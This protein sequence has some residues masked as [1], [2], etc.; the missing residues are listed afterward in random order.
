MEY[1][2]LKKANGWA[3][4]IGAITEAG[5][6]Y[7]FECVGNLEVLREAFLSTHTVTPSPYHSASGF[8]ISSI[9]CPPLIINVWHAYAGMGTDCTTWDSPKP[10]VAA[11]PSNGVI[12]RTP[13]R[14]I[15]LWRLQRQNPTAKVGQTMHVWGKWKV[16]DQFKSPA[17]FFNQSEFLFLFL[18]YDSRPWTWTSLSHMSFPSTT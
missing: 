4:R 16:N 2:G 13:N 8:P 18:E 14:R 5:V 11:S 12:W 7:S 17:S 1:N 15:H 9:C 6:D 10:D 3:Q